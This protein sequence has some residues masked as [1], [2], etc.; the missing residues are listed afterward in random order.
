MYYSHTISPQ[1]V[2]SKGAFSVHDYSPY[3]YDFIHFKILPF[4]CLFR[5]V[6]YPSIVRHDIPVANM[7]PVATEA[8]E[9]FSLVLASTPPGG[10]GTM[11]WIGTFG[12]INDLGNKI[13]V[14]PSGA[15]VA[16]EVISATGLRVN[17]HSSS[18]ILQY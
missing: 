14:K 6:I 13:S 11:R 1:G 2:S 18:A 16:T 4:V 12:L 17:K 3:N 5:L 10:S 15:I 8:P 9:A 7:S